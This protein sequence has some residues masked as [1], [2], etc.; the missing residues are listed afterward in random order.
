M[1][2]ASAP[3]HRID[4]A[5]IVCF[6]F[7]KG[8]VLLSSQALSAANRNQDPASRQESSPNKLI[9]VNP[10]C[11]VTG[12]QRLGRRSFTSA[13]KD[14][15]GPGGYTPTCAKTCSVIAPK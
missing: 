3:I 2:A 7:H 12:R 5:F 1:I 9:G 4:I 13:I 11:E 14:T 6:L 10:G 8:T 15:P